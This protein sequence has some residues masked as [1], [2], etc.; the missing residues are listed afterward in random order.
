LVSWIPD[1]HTG[2][3]PHKIATAGNLVQKVHR[4]LITSL[5]GDTWLALCSAASILISVVH[6]Q[7]HLDVAKQRTSTGRKILELI[8]TRTILILVS[9]FMANYA[10][11][12][13]CSQSFDSYFLK[14]VKNFDAI[15]EGK[16]YRDE[17]SRKG[18]LIIDNIYKGSFTKD[19]VEI[20]EGITDCTEAFMADSDVTLI[21]GLDKSTYRSSPR[22]YSAPSCVTS[23]LVLK[24]G[25]VESKTHFY[26]LQTRRPRIGL[27]S[28]VMRKNRF[29][30]KIKKR[31]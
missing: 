30:E 15:V 5:P 14:Q 27:F 1:A 6:K 23:V 31:L 3:T 13:S 22:A 24:N 11:G 10:L 26:N 20:A 17:N 28:T 21:L 19:T 7:N 29:V 9:I 18:Y 25:K 12:C 2:R 8:M 4:Y 16:F